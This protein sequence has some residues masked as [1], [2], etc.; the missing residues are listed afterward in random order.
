MVTL[1]STLLRSLAAIAGEP[2]VL[3]GDATAGFAVD[4][5][6]RFRGCTPAVVRPRDTAEVAAVLALCTDAGVPVVPQGGTPAWSAAAC[7]GTVRSY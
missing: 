2:H 1:P 4:W 5:T 7:P 3:T 6:G